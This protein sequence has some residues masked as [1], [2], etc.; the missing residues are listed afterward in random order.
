MITVLEYQPG[1]AQA[2]VP[3][4][5]RAARLESLDALQ[6]RAARL[7]ES[8]GV[9]QAQRGVLERQAHNKAEPYN[10]VTA[11]TQLMQ[12]DLQLAGAQAELSSVQTQIA[13]HQGGLPAGPGTIIVRPPGPRSFLD[14][15]D[16]R[17]LNAAFILTTLA[18]MIPISFGIMRRLW[19]Q[20]PKPVAPSL[21]DTLAPRFDRLEQSVDAIAIEIER[22]AEGQRF[23]TKVMAERPTQ[24]PAPGAPV[25]NDAS[26][27]GD[28]KPFLALGAGPIEP[29]RV[30]E[31]QAVRQSVTPH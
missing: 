2:P 8:I 20:T 4:S 26:G 11:S 31:R 22:I 17:A 14:R 6:A 24:S 21:A 1:P 18:I 23:V 30:G 15:I 16:P 25:V 12:V 5:P 28:A 29:I 9:L 3:A 13:M 27:L 19:R 7:Q 10:A